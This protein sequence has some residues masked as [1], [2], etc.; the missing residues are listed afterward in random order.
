[1]KSEKTFSPMNLALLILIFLIAGL[2]FFSLIFN[3]SS[4]TNLANGYT[5]NYSGYGVIFRPASYEKYGF[6][7][8]EYNGTLRILYERLHTT[9]LL[10]LI[11]TVLMVAYLSYSIYSSKSDIGAFLKSSLPK[12]ICA[13]SF[14]LVVFCFFFGWSFSEAAPNEVWYNVSS[15]IITKEELHIDLVKASTQ[16]YIPV[17]INAVLVGAYLILVSIKTKRES[18]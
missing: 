12:L 17:I 3:F 1:M 7:Y 6:A 5:E 8:V 2:G 16:F 10:Y 4:V 15:D 14:V 13:V 18:K 9:A 11:V